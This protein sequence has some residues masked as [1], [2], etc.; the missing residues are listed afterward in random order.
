[1]L[2][3]AISL[4]LALIILISSGPLD[5]LA[6][7]ADTENAPNEDT[8]QT[9][10]SEELGDFSFD[11]QPMAAPEVD[12][13]TGLEYVRLNQTYCEVTAYTGEETDLVIPETL[14]G[15]TVRSIGAD[16]FSWQE[17]LESVTLPE[18]VERICA[19]AFYGCTGLEQINIPD[20]VV[21]LGE[22]AFAECS[23][24]RTF[25]FPSKLERAGGCVWAGC[26]DL[27]TITV[28]EGITELQDYLF[29]ESCF[30][31]ILL[32]QSLV[33]LGNNVFSGCRE[34]EEIAIPNSVTEMGSYLLEYCESL[35]AV[36]LP[37]DLEILPEGIFYGCVYLQEIDLPQGLTEICY[38]AFSGCSRLRALALPDSVSVIG[39]DAFAN[40]SMLEQINYP[41]SLTT[42]ESGIF[43]GCTNLTSLEIPEGITEIPE[44]IFANCDVL[45][46]IVLPD[47]LE[48]IGNYAFQGCY[49]LETIELPQSLTELGEGAFE[50][51][52]SLEQIVIPAGIT[53]IAPYTFSGC[54][55]LTQVEL[56]EGLE[57]IEYNAFQYC[58]DLET[59]HIPDSV[60]YW[61]SSVFAGCGRLYEINY[62][63]GLV[64]S[65]T[66]VFYDCLDLETIT[67][68]EGVTSLPAYVFCDCNK[69]KTIV[70]PSTLTEIGEYAFS[71]CVRLEH[72]TLP[73][74]LKN[75]G[76]NAFEHCD[77]LRE[78]T[79][80]AG[81]TV[82]P[83]SLFYGCDRLN[84]VTLPEGMT[85]LG[86]SS[87]TECRNLIGILLPESLKVIGGSCFSECGKLASILLPEGLQQIGWAAFA[88]CSSLTEITIPDAVIEIEGDAF[89]GIENLVI[90]CHLNSYAAAYAIE[91]GIAIA[92]RS[93]ESVTDLYE[94]DTDR[95][96]YQI[97]YDGLS[98]SGIL[99][100]DL[101]YCF[102][103]RS[104]ASAQ[105]LTV[106]IPTSTQ[107]LEQTL[108]LDGK[109]CTDYEYY[110]EEGL[111]YIP[112][113]ESEGVVRF[114][115]KPLNY[116]RITSFA[117]I[118]FIDENNDYRT[119]V[120]G[121]V[122]AE[123]PIITLSALEE[124][125]E[126]TVTVTGVTM[127]ENTVTFFINGTEAG[128]T[129]A[130]LAGKY[131][132][133]LT[134]PEPS[135]GKQYTIRAQTTDA[136]G[137]DISAQT[138]VIYRSSTPVITDFVMHH[139]G[140]IQRMKDMEGVRPVVTFV[141]GEVFRFEVYVDQHETIESL[142]VVSTRSNQRKIMEASWDAQLGAYVAEGLFDPENESYVP[143]AI[144]V[145]YIRKNETVSFQT[146]YDFTSDESINLIPE[147]WKDANVVI[148]ENTENRHDVTV[149][150]SDGSVSVQ[151]ITTT[152][153]IPEGIT[154]ENAA[155]H[156]FIEV[157]DDYG[158]Q[159]WVR[160]HEENGAPQIDVLDWTEDVIMSQV[161]QLGGE[162]LGVSS[163][164]F[165]VYDLASALGES[166]SHDLQFQRMRNDII[167][168]NMSWAEKTA[169]LEQLDNAQKINAVLGITRMTGTLACAVIGGA[170]LGPVGGL[171]LSVGWG[172]VDHYLEYL[173][174]SNA[175]YMG[176]KSLLELM[177]GWAID[178]SG[179]V[180]DLTTG[181][182]LSGVTATAYWIPYDDA[183]VNFWD[184]V[185]DDTEYGEIWDAGE[186]SQMNPLV[187][188]EE[189]RYA[190]DVPEG[191]WRVEYRLEG[192]VT[193]WSDWMPVPPPQTEVNIGLLDLASGHVHSYQ[194]VTVAPTCTEQGYTTYT[195]A[196]CGDSYVDDYVDALGHNY[197]SV[198]T[199]PTCT[200]QGYTTHTC[201]NCGDSSV[202]TYVDALGHDMGAWI[203]DGAG[204]ERSD[205]GRCD[206]Y[207]T[208]EAEIIKPEAPAVQTAN[209]ASSGKIK[210]TWNKVDGAAKYQIWRSTDKKNWTLL[211]TTTGTS[212][213]NT[214]TEAGKLY[215]Y[216]VV[217]VAE[218]GTESDPSAIVS[219]RCDLPRPVITLSNVAST[220]KIKITWEKIEGAVKY[221]VYRSTDNKT[222]SK[223][224]TVSGTS[225]TNTSTTAGTLY[226]YKVKAIASNSGA[227]SAF[228]TVKS[229]RCDLARPSITSLTIISSTG[230]IKVKWGAVDGAVKYELYC[231]TDNVN[232]KRLTTTSGT[233]ISHN[234]AV[235]GT[236]YYYKVKAIASDT[237][238]N[239]AY[240]TVKNGYCD[241]ARP[242]LTVK[243]NSSGKPYLTW[244][245]ISGAVKYE[246]YRSTDGKS[247]TKL[248]TTTGTKLTNTS[249]KSGTTYYYKVRAI[250]S[251]S[252]ANSAYSTVKSI[253]A[254]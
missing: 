114:S 120:V 26:A 166:I 97:N 178:P 128:Q 84:S 46:Q 39:G 164:V 25:A 227:N 15:Y 54:T 9:E 158:N 195:C 103:D 55:R 243:L 59:V 74:S 160:Y 95:S 19:N 16:A 194:T 34:L 49:S 185:P 58:E 208:R 80:P 149:E 240:S 246:V 47:S 136:G 67:V 28:P 157:L 254:K 66:G 24:L 241:L 146:G 13:L 203:P 180:Y 31:E 60:E 77:Y 64:E 98:A 105:M 14:G 228:S 141:P 76:N 154:R 8:Q 85:E 110:A 41:L 7:T 145:E 209:V 190:W 202:D 192:Y 50:Y 56:P 27:E 245:K 69:L 232:W 159:A 35:T 91:N 188:D 44:Y 162:M 170:F 214:S 130:N 215:Y 183:V 239:S 142:L 251:V 151:V 135:N 108:T 168:S 134:L 147:D 200:E 182:R 235:A 12:E 124:T 165:T 18:T 119:E 62:P 231:S 29:A 112:V 167:N 242:T 43:A 171:I 92:E 115:I 229:R 121:V 11:F 36:T 204:Q 132:A 139:A 71:S 63:L 1:M 106:S 94:L 57:R 216:Y 81:I 30:R 237:S 2:K 17:E 247:W 233:S 249:A 3:R 205:C 196:E 101:R 65:G 87:F 221:E 79:I 230:K 148:N 45:Q 191:W 23:R 42:V 244:T 38:G 187:T 213:T 179:Y 206:Y 152:E 10:S 248:S 99:S 169:A 93:G 199:D 96:S 33:K 234:S 126:T 129:A 21:E 225:L 189:G 82:L 155:E 220:G 161:V 111:L 236:R 61:G 127:P 89:W 163:T 75:L 253:S 32:P 122:Y 175:H 212:L 109:L 140:Q 100:M 224:S 181:K 176:S 6:L 177:F 218:D 252:N 117:K 217:A 131:T 125:S 83:D 104:W 223:L 78:M 90:H 72:I 222:W 193:A 113:E 86:Y 143:G 226:Y 186:Y 172:L 197:E 137:N 238:A 53:T 73:G 184:A 144:T 156:G 37:E 250:A 153:Q 173:Q 4:L 68:P 107:L 70:L 52:E 88:N 51:C 5:V 150:K 102:K 211:K 116:D 123:L 20:G 219:R 198:V 40:C 22:R 138:L 133:A 201:A 210:L 48:R 174:D 118:E 207:E